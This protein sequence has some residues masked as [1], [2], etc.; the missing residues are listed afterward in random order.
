M[1]AACPGASGDCRPHDGG[2]ASGRRR[3]VGRA[4]AGEAGTAGLGIARIAG[5]SLK[6]AC[7]VAHLGRSACARFRPSSS[8]G[9][10]GANLGFPGRRPCATGWLRA[11]LGLARGGSVVARSV[12]GSS[13]CAG[14]VVGRACRAAAR[15]RA[16]GGPTGVSDS[17]LVESARG[18]LVGRRAACSSRARGTGPGT[19]R[20]D[21][22]GRAAG[23]RSRAA[24]DRGAVVGHPQDRGTGGPARPF[25][26]CASAAAPRLGHALGARACVVPATGRSPA[27]ATERRPGA[28]LV[29]SRR[30]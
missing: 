12:L 14:A 10:P 7:R 16:R 27:T 21:R 15:A 30:S 26:G 13:G 2:A 20:L 18:S 25:V 22:L 8:A 3:G 19:P 28:R 29:G 17:A 4:P 9:L 6:P 11:D 1:G 23:I 24:G 5:R